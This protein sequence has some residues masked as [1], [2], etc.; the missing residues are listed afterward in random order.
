MTVRILLGAI[1]VSGITTFMFYPLITLELINRHENAVAVGVILGLLSGVGRI[2]STFIGM[3]NAQWG[4][5]PVAI[6]GLILRSLGL[7]VFAFNAG[8]EIYALGAAVASIGSNATA[9]AIKTELMRAS[10][11][12]KTI[13]L[14]SIMINLGALV[15]PSLGGIVYLYA[16]FATI[17]VAVAISYIFLALSLCLITFHPPENRLTSNAKKMGL[18]SMNRSFALL[19]G[20][21]FCYWALYAMW[22][23]AV[24]ILAE[25]AFSTPIASSW[26][27]T[28]NALLILALQYVV[29]V[30]L[31]KDTAVIRVLC[32]GF[33]NFIVA[34]IVL[35][36]P[37]LSIAII[38]FATFFSIGEMLVSPTLD[39]VTARLQGLGMGMAKSFGL[40]GTIAGLASICASPI[41]GFLVQKSGDAS[42]VLWLGIPLALMGLVSTLALG[43][44]E[45][46]L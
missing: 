7:S 43:R 30:R 8:T 26:I 12:R 18:F 9:L 31:L 4:A 44:R 41:G 46:M 15:G 17:V 10:M 13:T 1:V 2:A 29:L 40:T 39:E 22:P 38:L 16:S 37:S 20:C 14:R 21:I 45:K 11:S 3:V 25:Q 35:V 19:S 34:F 33:V 5:R 6:G 27:Y 32:L 42:G 23:L 28:G 36:G 24:P